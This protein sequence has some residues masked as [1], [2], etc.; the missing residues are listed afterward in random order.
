MVPS[1][2]VEKTSCLVILELGLLDSKAVR[3]ESDNWGQS[4]SRS[5]ESGPLTCAANRVQSKVG[6]Q[7][8]GNTGCQPWL[9]L[10]KQK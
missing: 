9:S 6:T 8:K 7:P 3:K 10:K 1:L 4:G 5:E 2:K